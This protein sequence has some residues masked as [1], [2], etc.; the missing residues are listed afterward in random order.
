MLKIIEIDV[1]Q[2]SFAAEL[3]CLFNAVRKILLK[4]HTV[5][6]PG[7]K[8]IV[9]LTLNLLLIQLFVR[10]LIDGIQKYTSSVDPVDSCPVIVKPAFF[11]LQI[12]LVEA[13]RIN[14]ARFFPPAVLQHVRRGIVRQKCAQPLVA[15]ENP[16]T[17][18][19]LHIDS[20]AHVL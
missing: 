18:R 4:P 3:L 19:I 16:S 11:L 8:I 10:H 14:A 20:A 5:V 7:Q 1:E 6:K 9:C 17:D 2:R 13:V 15:V 12:D